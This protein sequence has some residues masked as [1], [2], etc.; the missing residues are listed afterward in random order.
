MAIGALTGLGMALYASG[1]VHSSV[2]LP[3]GVLI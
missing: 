2:V 3:M 1:L